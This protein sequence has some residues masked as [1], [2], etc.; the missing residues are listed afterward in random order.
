[1]EGLPILEPDCQ[2]VDFAGASAAIIQIDKAQAAGSASGGSASA[3]A[4]GST[5]DPPKIDWGALFGGWG[6]WWGLHCES[7]NPSKRH[8]IHLARYALPSHGRSC[9]IYREKPQSSREAAQELAEP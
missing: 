8:T 4:G 2:D 1:M 3:S 7:K 9:L 6:N 5:E